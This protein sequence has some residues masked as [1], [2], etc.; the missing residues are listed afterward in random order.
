LD[1]KPDPA[2]R[3]KT[4]DAGENDLRG[5]WHMRELQLRITAQLIRESTHAAILQRGMP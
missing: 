5:F 3:G 2:H 4:D 1:Q